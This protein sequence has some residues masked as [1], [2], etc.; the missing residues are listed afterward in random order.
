VNTS[1]FHRLHCKSKESV[2]FRE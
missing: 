2:W 1:K